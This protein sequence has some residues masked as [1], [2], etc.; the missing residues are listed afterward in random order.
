MKR[1]G[2][3]VNFK[4]KITIIVFIALFGVTFVHA[5]QPDLRDM[6]YGTYDDY[7]RIVF[8]FSGKVRPLINDLIAEQNRVELI[9]SAV[10]FTSSVKAYPLTTAW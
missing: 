7:T 8:E 5:Q 3:Q 9:F 10:N 1:Y 4:M 2:N 6:R